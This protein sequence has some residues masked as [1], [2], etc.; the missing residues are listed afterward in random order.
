MALEPETGKP[1]WAFPGDGPGYSSPI[2]ATF[3]GVEQVVTQT[4]A[5]IVSVALDSGKLLWRIPFT[6]PYDQ[7]IVT[8]VRSGE[9]LV[10]SGLEADTFA[11]EPKL[12]ANG[13]EP[14]EIWRSETTFYMSS[15]LV[16][17]DH[18]LGFSNQRK[19]QLV[20]L[21]LRWTTLGKRPTRDNS[22]L[23]L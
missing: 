11:V 21:D 9:R 10:F 12:G 13:F 8:P 14:R 1:V 3:E 19:G 2:V 17:F 23:V 18:L 7:N 6:T 15:P 20:A 22:A 16:A 4:D 5:H